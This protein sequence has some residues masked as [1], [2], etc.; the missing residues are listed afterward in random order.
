MEGTHPVRM[1][2][3]ALAALLV[4][5][6][7]TLRW[8]WT[9][10]ADFE[11]EVERAVLVAEVRQQG[12]ACPLSR[13]AAD[14]APDWVLSACMTGG[15]GWYDAAQRYG[16]DAAGIF[17]V[18]GADEEFATVFD[19]L[20][21]AVVPVVAYF[22]RNG[23]TQYL[24]HE[25]LGQGLSRVWNDGEAGFAELTPEQYG[26]I[27][28]HELDR[29]GHEMLSEFEIVGGVAVRKPLTRA[30]FGVKNLVF[31]GASD[32]EAVIARGE[33]LPTW[34]EM[35]WAAVDAAIVVGGIGAATRAV[36]VARVPATVSARGTSRAIHLRAA[37]QGAV[38]SLATV[39]K[40]AG[41]AAIVAIPY[42]AIT[43]P[44]LV[45]G[46]GGW[47]AEQA[48]LPGWLGVFGVYALLCLA[49]VA[50]LRIV[51]RP[52]MWTTLMIGRAL[53]WIARLTGRREKP[54]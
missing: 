42:V 37:G 29:R 8:Q 5:L 54:A 14:R 21:H 19:R 45:A 41:V 6:A 9:D 16:E 11:A 10:R 53:G 33:R 27:A 50:L 25:T 15:L 23:S 4:A 22:V 47:L 32:L 35:G 1:R 17:S 20:G 40:A 39:G 24:L 43:R 34:G 12:S 44:H 46:A 3:L 7:L 18:Y 2:Y 49:L 36:R 26:L 51:L 38:R 48:G 30:L 52:V 31:G 28:I 13:E